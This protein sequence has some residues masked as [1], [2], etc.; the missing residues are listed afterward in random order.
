MEKRNIQIDKETAR[1]WYNG[2]DNTLKEL[3]LQAF[4]EEELKE[5]TFGRIYSDTKVTIPTHTS[6]PFNQNSKWSALHK[7]AIIAEYLNRGWKPNWRDTSE[8]KY[9]IIKRG[10]TIIIDNL[11]I[12]NYGVVVFNSYSS[13]EKAIEIMGKEINYI[14]D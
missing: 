11:Q 4:K 12:S 1:K 13:A 10:N 2:N 9:Y 14:F 3:A 5:L 8:N 6:V 7:L